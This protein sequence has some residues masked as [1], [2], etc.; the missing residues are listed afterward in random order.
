MNM[1]TKR[2]MWVVVRHRCSWVDWC[3]L[4]LWWNWHV[5]IHFVMGSAECG[6]DRL[7]HGGSGD[8]CGRILCAGW[9]CSNVTLSAL[10]EGWGG[11][12]GVGIESTHACSQ[13]MTG[14]LLISMHQ[15]AAK[16]MG[17]Q[18]CRLMVSFASCVLCSLE[19]TGERGICLSEKCAV[20][21][22]CFIIG[23]ESMAVS[24]WRRM[25]KCWEEICVM[26]AAMA[27]WVPHQVKCWKSW[28]LVELA[29]ETIASSSSR[30]DNGWV[31]LEVHGG[32]SPV[33]KRAIMVRAKTESFS[34]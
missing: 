27:W 12:R 13:L 17:V 23:E 10:S 25:T 14:W 28:C 16:S 18:G 29:L 22:V 32:G 2:G 6:W 21:V 9:V 33:A 7:Y 11:E 30:I 34:T 15:M 3:K 31:I 20:G 1:E 5:V 4:L 26:W 19:E 24:W 8:C